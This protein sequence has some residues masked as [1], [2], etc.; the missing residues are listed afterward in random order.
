[1]TGTPSP[2]MD[3][4][5]LLVDIPSEESGISTES[6]VLGETWVGMGSSLKGTVGTGRCWE[7]WDVVQPRWVL[8]GAGRGPQDCQESRHALSPP[9]VGGGYLL[10]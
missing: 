5:L 7:C 10:K 9:L 2:V 1:M 3:I 8:P 4:V 6:G